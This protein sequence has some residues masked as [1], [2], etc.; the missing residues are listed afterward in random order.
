MMNLNELRQKAEHFRLLA[1]DSN[2]MRMAA[3]LHELAEE[4]DLEA[5]NIATREE[6]SED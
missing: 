1:M 3:V 5:A 6:T 2:D 4:F